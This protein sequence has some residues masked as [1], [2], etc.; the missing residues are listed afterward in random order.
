MDDRDDSSTLSLVEDKQNDVEFT[1]LAREEALAH[2]YHRATYR[3]QTA[4]NRN[5]ALLDLHDQPVSAA[6]REL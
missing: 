5:A 3:S 2:L 4:E 1:R 6:E